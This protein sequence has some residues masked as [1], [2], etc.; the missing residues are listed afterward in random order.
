MREICLSIEKLM[1]VSRQSTDESLT[2][3]HD[4]RF[5]DDEDY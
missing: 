1:M 3:R 2:R 5:D 4:E